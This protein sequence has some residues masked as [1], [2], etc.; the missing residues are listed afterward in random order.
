[1]ATPSDLIAY[2]RR[3]GYTQKGDEPTDAFSDDEGAEDSRSLRRA[4]RESVALIK[5][6]ANELEHTVSQDEDL[7]RGHVVSKG[8]IDAKGRLTV[9]VVGASR[10]SEATFSRF[11]E[12]DRAHHSQLTQESFNYVNEQTHTSKVSDGHRVSIDPTVLLVKWLDSEHW[13]RDAFIATISTVACLLIGFS[14]YI[15]FGNYL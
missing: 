4:R 3:K 7:R 15:I 6:K 13:K 11:R 2:Y 1:M 12:A 8:K 10:T 5:S 14:I 9:D